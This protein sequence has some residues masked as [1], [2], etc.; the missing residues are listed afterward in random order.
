MQRGK[1]KSNERSGRIDGG[2]H[3]R[4]TPFRARFKLVVFLDEQRKEGFRIWAMGPAR[5][6]LSR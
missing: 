1:G 6:K 5:D 3:V 4:T 2:T